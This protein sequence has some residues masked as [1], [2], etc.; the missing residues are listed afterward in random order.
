MLDAADAFVMALEIFMIAPRECARRA[1]GCAFEVIK[2]ADLRTWQHERP[3]LGA[4]GVIRRDHAGLADARHIVTADERQH[5]I[6]RSKIENKP[7]P[8]AFG[9]V[10]LLAASAA[11][12]RRDVGEGREVA[13][14]GCGGRNGLAVARDKILRKRHHFDHALVGFA[15]AIAE[16]DDAVF[17]QNEPIARLDALENFDGFFGEAEARHQIRYKRQSLAKDFGAL[18]LAVGLVDQTQHRGRVRMIDEFMRQEGVQHHLDGRVGGRRINQV[19]ALDAD[20][21][22]VA[23]RIE[24]A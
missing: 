22:L 3:V 9:P 23:D 4:D 11:H 15:R 8:G 6:G 2:F 24:F 7:A 13:Q 12:D 20:E 1:V 10:I 5:R 17:A 21:F 16:G 18:L 19:G 14:R